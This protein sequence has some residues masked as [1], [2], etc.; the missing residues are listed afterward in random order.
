MFSIIFNF[1]PSP[2]PLPKSQPSPGCWKYSAPYRHQLKATIKEKQK[3]LSEANSFLDLALSYF[4]FNPAEVSRQH[5]VLWLDD[6][7][8]RF[9]PLTAS[10]SLFFSGRPAAARWRPAGPGLQT[11]LPRLQS[12]F[13]TSAHS[14]QPIPQSQ[15][16][17]P[18]HQHSS[19]PVQQSPAL[20]FAR[21]TRT[22]IYFLK[23]TRKLPFLSLHT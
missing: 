23:P 1:C 2:P 5:S 14:S 18:L 20:L 22:N 6:P 13:V 10:L 15:Q 3:E 12:H 7:R 11:F 16:C 19:T 21:F 4:N 8:P 9:T 17:P